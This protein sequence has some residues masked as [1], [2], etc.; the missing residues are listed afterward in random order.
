LETPA[1]WITHAFDP[2]FNVAMRATSLEMPQFLQQFYGLS[3]DDAYSLISVAA[4][5]SI[6]Q[7]VDERQGVH[8]SIPKMA[9]LPEKIGKH[10]ERG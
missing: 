4:D 8:V 10:N 6:T 9:R 2:D 1:A 5:F 3:K 7:V